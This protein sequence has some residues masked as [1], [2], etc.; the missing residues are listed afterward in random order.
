MMLEDFNVIEYLNQNSE[1]VVFFS[2]TQY[3][4]S[5]KTQLFDRISEPLNI[6]FEC[7]R[8]GSMAQS[9]INRTIPYLNMKSVGLVVDSLVPLN[10]I[11]TILTTPEIQACEL[12]QNKT[13][14]TT[15]S[16]NALENANDIERNVSA[17]HC[18][19]GQGGNAVNLKI[20]NINIS[21]NYNEKKR[22]RDF[23]DITGGK[24]HSSK[25]KKRQTK[26]R[27]TKRRKTKRRRK[28]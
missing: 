1:N 7:I 16:L 17:S 22:H 19:G 14:E 25:N 23:P 9:N 8:V 15:V 26:R 6:K 11:K 27:K 18:Q 28:N 3:Y 20:I 10:E 2:N 4:P 21:S 13:I 24:S 5:T 12:V